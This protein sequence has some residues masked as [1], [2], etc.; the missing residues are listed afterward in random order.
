MTDEHQGQPPPQGE[1]WAGPMGER[2]LAHLDR[3]E[4]MLQDIGEAVIAKAAFKPGERVLDV[5]CGGGWTCR[6][7]AG[8]VGPSGSVTGL[9]VSP[10]LVEEAGARAR[11]AGAA[12]VRFIAGDAAET[13]VPDAGFDR[14]FSRF[15]IMFFADPR[16]AFTH[17]HGLMRPG[18][19]LIFAC[20]GPPEEN[21]WMRDLMGV[22]RKYAPQPAP[23]APPPDPR[24]PGPLA[25][26]DPDY[27]REVLEA[28]GFKQ[29]QAEPWRGDQYIGGRGTTPEGAAAFMCEALGLNDL[30]AEQPAEARAQAIEE[31][32]A[33]FAKGH[34]PEG[35]RMGAMAWFVTATA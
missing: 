7:I 23:G 33:M 11:K 32:T 9:D 28:G 10:A 20:W 1:Q 29:V 12:S 31:V 14:L 27:V 2:W 30:L 4:A 3:F 25:F 15:G 26:A 13:E 19:G 16:A 18:G 5:G 8:R 35:V 24:A 6:Q 34:G 17:L 22:T 21:P